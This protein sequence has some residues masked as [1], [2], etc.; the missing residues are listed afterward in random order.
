[1]W[2]NLALESGRL[3]LVI[4][5]VLGGSPLTRLCG[6]SC[7]VAW[8][9]RCDVFRRNSSR[10]RRRLDWHLWLL[11]IWLRARW[12][13]SRGRAWLPGDVLPRDRLRGP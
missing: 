10:H 11:P 5:P 2:L 4:F 7:G 3:G 9:P 1:M 8:G 6:V 12:G 13:I